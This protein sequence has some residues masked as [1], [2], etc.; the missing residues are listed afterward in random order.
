MPGPSWSREVENRTRKGVC[1][2]TRLPI[3][4]SVAQQPYLFIIQ[5]S[6][7]A[8]M[9]QA[10]RI[11]LVLIFSLTRRTS[12]APRFLEFAEAAYVLSW[13]KI[14]VRSSSAWNLAHN[15][16]FGRPQKACSIFCVS[17]IRSPAC[18]I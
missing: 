3:E 2:R 11:R 5:L 15:A 6:A 12:K 14:I 16:Y 17:V 9:S 8:L 1:A 4:K 18:S 7:V 13:K 10:A